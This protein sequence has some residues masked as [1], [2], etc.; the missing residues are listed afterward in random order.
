MKPLKLTLQAFGPFSATETIDFD[1]LGTHPL[2][3]INGPTGAGKSSILDGICFAL[4]GKTTTAD[5]S[6]SQMRC[7]FADMQLLTEVTLD[8]CLADKRYRI[9]RVPMQERA[10]SV[11][12]GTT[13]QQ[14]KA[15]LWELD[16]SP[17]HRLMVSGSVTEADGEIKGLIGLE[18]EQF[19]QVMVLPQGKFRELLLADSKEREKIFGQLFQTS[20][21]KQ[22]E[23]VFKLK[24]S[25][26][27]KSVEQHQNQIMGILQSAD[28]HSEEE[29]KLGLET[30]QPALIEA[31][32]NKTTA[33]NNLKSLEKTLEAARQ[34][35]KQFG[36]LQRK[37]KELASHQLHQPLIEDKK[38]R[39]ELASLAQALL[40]IF[41]KKQ[42]IALRWQH[43]QTSLTDSHNKLTETQAQLANATSLFEQAAEAQTAVAPMGKQLV[44]FEQ[45]L[46]LAK[47]LTQLKRLAREQHHQAGQS[48][49][50]TQAAQAEH[51]RLKQGIA[52][53]T[54]V[55][56]QL[57]GEVGGLPEEQVLLEK[58]TATLEGL[59]QLTV[60][61]AELTALQQVTTV[62]QQTL[63][64]AKDALLAS[65]TIANTTELSWHVNQA[66]I[67]AKSLSDGQPCPVCGS[68]EHPDV[69]TATEG[70]VA[71]WEDVEAAREQVNQ[72]TCL[73]DQAKS[74]CDEAQ[75]KEALKASLILERV[76]G[77]GENGTQSLAV[78]QQQVHEQQ[79]K[80]N[81]LQAAKEKLDSINVELLG[82]KEK[83]AQGEVFI[84]TLEKQSVLDHEQWLVANTKVEQLQSRVPER[85]QDAGKIESEILHL[86]T[87]I[88]QL[89]S[90]LESARDNQGTSQSLFDQA[91]THSQSLSQQFIEVEQENEQAKADWDMAINGSQFDNESQFNQAWLS[92]E[93]QLQMKAEIERF[94][95]QLDQLKGAQKQLEAELKDR[96]KPLLLPLEDE[97][98]QAG[99][100]LHHSDECWRQYQER[101]NQLLSVQQKLRQAHEKNAALEQQ[102]QTVGTLYE[103]S[104]GIGINDERLSLQRFVLSVLLDDVLIQ[105]SQRLSLMS[106]GRYQLIRK[107]QRARG[108]KASGLEL[109]VD[110]GY[111]GKSRPVAT[112]SG[113]ESFMAALSLALG[114]SD[115]VQSYSGG[116]RLDT[117]FIDEGFGSLDSES[118]DLAVRTLIDLQ[119]SGRMIG[120]I[121][122][123]T[124]LK[125]QMGLRIDVK[126]GRTG[127]QISTITV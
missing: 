18:V 88:N 95:S 3:L 74:A 66:T 15:T 105:A 60:A 49:A 102:Y 71:T 113:G 108:N 73:R 54:S 17:N 87:Q 82:D 101:N 38:Q 78:I 79:N 5:R 67:L 10:K 84:Q 122:H 112:L 39:L 7:D 33:E 37:K 2:F 47:E 85:Y 96:Q 65:K 118:L 121:S 27:K 61:Q 34:L 117:L 20:I 52:A 22:I 120:I 42:D 98:E 55:V 72:Q 123:V 89:N 1:R 21:Y 127:S 32:N 69:A 28:L 57:G 29:I 58:R 86:T 43:T 114:L 59:K 99:L 94:S 116:I 25:E 92:E 13:T 8:F 23:E 70:E 36:L 77:L 40:P 90:A 12:E 41:S 111:T 50:K 46:I 6:P 80:V 110:D 19:R 45:Y 11:G 103:V 93:Q 35:E 64:S 63:A 62:A 9:T 97:L 115:V 107:Q 30:L 16:G 106:K 44:E 75:G 51:N 125:S 83:Q 100:E 48:Q 104:N 24:A 68:A 31:L 124:E 56:E 126:S 81:G 4:Y 119:S 53:K 76:K 109:E 14:S 91:N 26:I